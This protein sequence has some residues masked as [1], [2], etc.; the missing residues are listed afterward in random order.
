MSMEHS[1][2]LEEARVRLGCTTA[3]HYDTTRKDSFPTIYI[4]FRYVG[5][6]KASSTFSPDEN[7][8][9][10]TLPSKFRLIT[11]KNKSP[12]LWCP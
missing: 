11:E 1:F 5:G 2:W 8:T 6:M 3:Q 7:S 12:F 9:R 4:P 10:I